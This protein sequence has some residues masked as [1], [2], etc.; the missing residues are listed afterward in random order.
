MISA[1][2]LDEARAINQRRGRFVRHVRHLCDL[3][4]RS[5]FEAFDQIA[6][7]G[8]RDVV[9]KVVAHI[10]TIDLDALAVTGGDRF[11]DPPL[12]AVGGREL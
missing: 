3:G 5:V 7:E 6:R 2:P 12:R 4:P 11:P 9:E 10:A 8:D 1:L